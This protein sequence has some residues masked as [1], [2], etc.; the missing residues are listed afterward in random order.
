MT[1]EYPGVPE[2]DCRRVYENNPEGVERISFEQGINVV[3]V[4]DRSPG[5]GPL[6]WPI[7]DLI[8][9]R[10]FRTMFKWCQPTFVEAAWLIGYAFTL[11]GDRFAYELMQEYLDGPR[12]EPIRIPFSTVPEYYDPYMEEG[13]HDPRFI[14]VS[15]IVEDLTAHE[16]MGAA[17]GHTAG[18]ARADFS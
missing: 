1:I 5:R 7:H 8:A 6:K 2:L 18:L 4:F 15:H 17:I 9:E 12:R 3:L 10:S 14:G 16:S 13:Y 11:H